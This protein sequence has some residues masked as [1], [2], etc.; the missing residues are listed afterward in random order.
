MRSLDSLQKISMTLMGVLVLLTFVGSNVQALFWPTSDWLVS[1]VLSAVVVDLTN[2]EREDGVVEPLVRNSVLDKAATR[3]AEHMAE[4]GYFAHYSPD[5]VS[6]WHW[7]REVGYTYAYAGENLAIHFSD[8]TE[9]VKAWM[10][11]PTH[12]DN[13]VNGLYREIGVGTARGQ[14]EG[15]DTV[16]VV[17]LFGAPAESSVFDMDS[18]SELDNST[19]V[20]SEVGKE[21][22]EGVTVDVP[23]I[24]ADSLA[25]GSVLSTQQSEPDPKAK[26][27]STIKV[28]DNT[29]V[30][31]KPEVDVVK[32][33]INKVSF[34]TSFMTDYSGLPPA[35]IQSS[36]N[37]NAGAT[38]TSLLT[39]PGQL[40]KYLQKK[41]LLPP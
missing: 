37:S 27:E 19:T 9:V 28:A 15:Y 25:T 18:N 17:Q 36:N 33:N 16:F 7:F 31:S 41:S 5:G 14:F 30:Q 11:S 21:S 24:A 20:I 4:N 34:H 8:S 6:P 1:T 22:G 29:N 35:E 2:E 26:P 39:K 38:M 13:I 40:L 12:R 32:G 23:T 10:N 3:K